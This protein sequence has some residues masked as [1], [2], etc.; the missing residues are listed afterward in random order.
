MT[1]VEPAYRGLRVRCITVLLHVHSTL[2]RTRIC[3]GRLGISCP[4]LLD[5][6]GTKYSARDSNP[7][8]EGR[9]LLSYPLNERSI[10]Y[11]LPGSGSNRRVQQSKCCALP[12]GDRATDYPGRTRT[13][14]D[15]NQT[16]A[17]Y[18]FGDWALCSSVYGIRRAVWFVATPAEPSTAPCPVTDCPVYGIF[19][20]CEAFC[21]SHISRERPGSAGP[22]GLE[23]GQAVLET[24]VLSNYT[25]DLYL[26]CSR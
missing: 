12:F 24:A 18:Q 15:E 5:E 22:P 20:L 13:A 26:T 4:I 17:P 2:Y 6:Q 7:Y 8:W 21:C 19:I 23:P 16:L 25:T 10:I 3:I 14:S 1:G 9:S 11:K